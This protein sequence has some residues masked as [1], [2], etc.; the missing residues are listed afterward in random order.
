VVFPDPLPEPIIAITFILSLEL[1]YFWIGI[2]LSRDDAYQSPA[3][4]KST[5]TTTT[6]TPIC[7]PNP[8]GACTLQYDPVCGVDGNT[9]SNECFARLVCV[10]IAYAGACVTTTTIPPGNY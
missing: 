5:T 4:T 1:I 7:I 2:N 10:D 3:L 9:Y 6:T 8:D